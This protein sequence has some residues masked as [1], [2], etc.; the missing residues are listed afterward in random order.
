MPRREEKGEV[1]PCIHW[2]PKGKASPHLFTALL[3]DDLDPRGPRRPVEEDEAGPTEEGEEVEQDETGEDWVTNST[4]SFEDT[5][6]RES[7]FLLVAAKHQFDQSGEENQAEVYTYDSEN[8]SL[9]IRNSFVLPEM[10]LCV[11]WIGLQMSSQYSSEDYAVRQEFA[12]FA[13]FGT[14][15]PAIEIFNLDVQ[16]AILP[17]HVLG[18]CKKRDQNNQVWPK[19]QLAKKLMAGSHTDAILSMQWNMHQQTFLA[20][21]SADQTVKIW[22]LTTG[23]C[24]LTMKNNTAPVNNVRWNH[25]GKTILT[26][27]L[28]NTASVTNCLDPKERIQIM[29]EGQPESAEWHPFNPSL[30]YVS[31]GNGEIALYEVRKHATPLWKFHAHE[32]A[33]SGLAIHPTVDGLIATGGQDQEVALWDIRQPD[34]PKPI[35]RKNFKMGDVLAVHWNRDDP[36]LLGASGS[37]GKV[38]VWTVTEEVQGAGFDI[39]PAEMATE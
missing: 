27:S 1:I 19:E 3:G 5:V 14:M 32:K 31:T 10:P 11:T 18:G 20:S 35:A 34:Q 33:C 39:A 2:I 15:V 30:F 16:N 21:G 26:T 25:E 24:K 12:N 29:L 22:D 4:A 7:D 8:D 36:T 6:L 17:D 37:K 23:E 9:F 38:L 13:A 28:D